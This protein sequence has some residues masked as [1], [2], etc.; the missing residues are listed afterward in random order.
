MFSVF[1]STNPLPA[2]CDA[3]GLCAGATTGCAAG[4]TLVLATTEYTANTIPT[5]ANRG[6]RYFLNMVAP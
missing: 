1:D 2:I 6:R 5:S 4:T 3:Y